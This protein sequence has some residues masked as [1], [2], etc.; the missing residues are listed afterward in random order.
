MKQLALFLLA[1]SSLAACE[2]IPV[3]AGPDITLDEP[4]YAEDLYPAPS[5]DEMELAEAEPAPPPSPIAP[6]CR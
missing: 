2:S 5:V 3:A 6:T 1:T 4:D